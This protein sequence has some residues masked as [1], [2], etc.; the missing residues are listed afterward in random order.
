M[1]TRIVLTGIL[2]DDDL[3]L[4]VKRNE[5]D[6]TFPGTWEF[7]GGHLEEGETIQECLFR[8]LKEELGISLDAKPIIT[9][10]TDEI[11]NKNDRL[12]HNIEIDFIINVKKEDINV[13]L[14]PEHTEYKWL[15]KDSDLLD[16]YIKSKLDNI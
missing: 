14:S 12:I 9:N 5:N 1:E 6:D 13:T 3:L 16:E 10:Y 8:E 15:D 4:A 7:L 11:K 2:K